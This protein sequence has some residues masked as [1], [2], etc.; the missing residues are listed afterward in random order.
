MELDF[1]VVSWQW[2]IYTVVNCGRTWRDCVGV[3]LIHNLY[4]LCQF[5][6]LVAKSADLIKIIIE[7]RKDA[8]LLSS[9]DWRLKNIGAVSSY[10]FKKKAW[11]V[12][13]NFVCAEQILKL[14]IASWKPYT[15]F[16]RDHQI[17]IRNK[18]TNNEFLLYQIDS[19]IRT[20]SPMLFSHVFNVLETMIVAKSNGCVADLK[21]SQSYLLKHSKSSFM[22]EQNRTES[23]I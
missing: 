16:Q 21:S 2:K 4:Y 14:N 18:L 8:W 12:W 11:W 19:Q 1:V 22:S 5:D 6:S 10:E 20:L 7:T 15:L 9:V 13:E 23:K 3:S 17:S